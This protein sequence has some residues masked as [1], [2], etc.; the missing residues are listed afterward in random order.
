MGIRDD[1]DAAVANALD[2]LAE[3]QHELDSARNVVDNTTMPDF[4]RWTLRAL[5]SSAQNTAHNDARRRIMREL[6]RMLK[7]I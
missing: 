4:D 5:L 2:A 3:R 6:N 7:E 1:F